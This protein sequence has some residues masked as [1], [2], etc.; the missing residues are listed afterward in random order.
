MLWRLTIIHPFSGI[1]VRTSHGIAFYLG[2]CESVE[3][4][5]SFDI[6]DPIYKSQNLQT[7]Q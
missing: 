2:H 1:C 6:L 4:N 3:I 5:C 7:G